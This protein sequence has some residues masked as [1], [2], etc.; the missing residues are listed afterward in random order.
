VSGTLKPERK[1]LQDI[2]QL[3]A[4]LIALEAQQ[5]T[6]KQE[7]TSLTA[8]LDCCQVL[9]KV[10]REAGPRMTSALI[11][12][13]RVQA[14]RIFHEITQHHDWELL[15]NEDFLAEIKE[16]EYSRSFANLSG[17][18]QMAVALAIRLA[19]IRE[20]SDVRIAFFDEPTAH[21]DQDRRRGLARMISSISDFDQLFVISHD[22]TFE[23]MT[24]HYIFVDDENVRS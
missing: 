1:R 7:C 13:I 24:D 4:E 20:L 12:S 14:N 6:L 8:A 22:D 17:G 21:M 9:R 16:G 3:V 11:E 19:L 5:Q 10:I 15:W 23:S 18:E 2:Q